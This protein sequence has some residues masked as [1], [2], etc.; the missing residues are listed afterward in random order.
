MSQFFTLDGQNIGASA[1]ASILPVNISGLISF[2]IDWFDHLAVRGTLKSLLQHHSSKASV[3]QHSAF[4][5]VQLPRLY[6][7][8]VTLWP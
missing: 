8:T 5:I 4:S 2:R 1:S 3:L 7:T 6:M